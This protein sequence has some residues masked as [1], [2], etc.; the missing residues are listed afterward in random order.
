LKEIFL[1]TTL[2]A[3]AL[4][5]SLT[6]EWTPDERWFLGLTLGGT[7]LGIAVARV[8]RRGVWMFGTVAGTLAGAIAA[9][10]IIQPWLSALDEVVPRGLSVEHRVALQY[11]LAGAAA[12]T[13]ALG[14]L[15]AV[16]VV[17]GYQVLAW[18]IDFGEQGMASAMRRRPYLT[19]AMAAM[20]VVLMFAA[21]NLDFLREPC[22]WSPRHF[23]ELGPSP[24]VWFN[25]PATEARSGSLSR[26]GNWL[27]VREYVEDWQGES[28][29]YRLDPH[30][31]ATPITGVQRSELMA[32][33]CDQDR[34]AY[35]RA[36]GVVQVVDLDTLSSAPLPE[37]PRG[38]QFHSLQWLPGGTLVIHHGDPWG[39][40]RGHTKLSLRDGRWSRLDSEE[41]VELHPWSGKLLERTADGAR[42]VD[43]NSSREIASIPRDF[44]DALKGRIGDDSLSWLQPSPD[45]RYVVAGMALY[46]LQPES[47]RNRNE[48]DGVAAPGCYG[49]LRSGHAVSYGARCSRGETFPSFLL[50][51]PFGARIALWL[52]RE[53]IRLVDP[54]SGK[55]VARTR[56]LVS[57]PLNVTLSHDG[58]RMAVFCREGVL[59]YDVPEEFR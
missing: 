41:Q 1:L 18:G 25:T 6:P 49:F 31:H 45:G 40:K 17:A 43:L 2:A 37:A 34:M 19:A 55:E 56:P 27:I 30:P 11:A 50:H 13:I 48:V 46:S 3:A 58:S 5:L 54:D 44:L 4:A 20:V 9:G 29:L 42:I 10:I 57:S 47:R 16:L 15:L 23:I 52:R 33:D 22:A 28:T 53:P 36:P 26:N 38:A 14:A 59:I 7:L 8:F 35:F 32:F 24:S 12:A 39:W 51:V 21:A